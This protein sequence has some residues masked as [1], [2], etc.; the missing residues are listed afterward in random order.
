MPSVFRQRCAFS[1]AGVDRENSIPQVYLLSCLHG[2]AV[3]TQLPFLSC[4][5]PGWKRAAQVCFCFPDYLKE[6]KK[7]KVVF[8]VTLSYFHS[9]H[10]VLNIVVSLS[11]PVCSFMALQLCAECRT[12]L[13]QDLFQLLSAFPFP[14]A[15]HFGLPLSKYL[16][17]RLMYFQKWYN[18]CICKYN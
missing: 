7:R 9:L 6:R 10:I 8:V 18:E 3:F 17:G 1:K 15:L 5:C 2:E 12:C 4:L 11:L 16:P 14:K 13:E